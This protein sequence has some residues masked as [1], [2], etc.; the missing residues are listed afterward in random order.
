MHSGLTVFFKKN[1]FPPSLPDATLT[2]IN[3]V[4]LLV[5]DNTQTMYFDDWIKKL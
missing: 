5:T 3:F 4:Y 2:F 1:P